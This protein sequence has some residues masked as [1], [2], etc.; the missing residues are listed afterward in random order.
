MIDLQRLKGHK[1]AHVDWGKVREVIPT[2]RFLDS[3]TGRLIEC[4]TGLF[5]KEYLPENCLRE[6]RKSTRLTPVTSRSRMP[7]SA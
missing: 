4:K 7:S 6:D 1:I 2:G 3:G 5:K